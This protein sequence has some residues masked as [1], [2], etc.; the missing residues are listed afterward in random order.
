MDT[1]I[2]AI[3]EWLKG[4]L[5][6]GIMGNLDGLFNN[7]NEQ[8]GGIASQVGT[9]PADFNAGVFSMIRQISET[10]VLPIAGIILTF[11]M[12]YPVLPE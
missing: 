3:V 12:T 2:N 7:V 6:D 1:I 5:V 8:V 11:V 9:T 4:V 10:V